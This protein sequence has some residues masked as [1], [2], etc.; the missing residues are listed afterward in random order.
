MAVVNV[1][2]STQANPQKAIKKTQFS[3]GDARFIQQI[4]RSDVYSNKPRIII[5]EYLSNA[6]D[7]HRESQKSLTPVEIKLPT[8][9][10]NELVIRDYG[11]GVSPE[12]FENVFVQYGTSTKRDSDRQTGG[13]GIGAKSAWAYT[14]EYF[15]TSWTQEGGTMMERRYRCYVADDGW[16]YGAL[17]HED[18][19]NE[20]QQ[21]TEIS[22]TIKPEDHEKFLESF[23]NVTYFWGVRPKVVGSYVSY[24]SWEESASGE[25]WTLFQRYNGIRNG[26]V[27]IIDGIPYAVM[28]EELGELSPNERELVSLPIHFHAETGEVNIALNRESLTY[29]EKTVRYLKEKINEVITDMVNQV[30]AALKPCA[31]FWLAQTKWYKEFDNTVIG[32]IIKHAKWNGIEVGHGKLKQTDSSICKMHK[33]TISHREQLKPTITMRKYDS[34]E[35]KSDVRIVVND[36]DKSPSPNRLISV[37]QSIPEVSTFYVVTFD[38]ENTNGLEMRDFWMNELHLKHMGPIFTSNFER[39]K[40]PKGEKIPKIRNK[41]SIKKVSAQIMK[42]VF[43]HGN[44]FYSACGVDTEIDLSEIEGY[45]IETVRGTPYIKEETVPRNFAAVL[46][47]LFKNDDIYYVPKPL[48]G[49]VKKQSKLKLIDEEFDKRIQDYRKNTN[50]E[51]QMRLVNSSDY[52][53]FKNKHCGALIKSIGKSKRLPADHIFQIWYDT[54]NY[55][56]KNLENSRTLINEYTDISSELPTIEGFKGLPILENIWS[57]ITSK[58]PLLNLLESGYGFDP[59]L[60]DRDAFIEYIELKDGET[61]K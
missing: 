36:T 15:V 22:L 1:K 48:W 35:Y 45:Y 29:D 37:F 51:P 2:D 9:A 61:Y 4:L 7:A 11:P 31:N 32:K 58:Y 40:P 60:Q 42:S 16:C 6:R 50:I 24:R 47:H 38:R 14:D 53:S 23:H 55:I 10:N 18:I 13:F 21:G 59:S 57:D 33:V 49:K 26:P 34:W 41:L 27:A 8:P 52:D 28:P 39:W 43:I 46:Y 25:N 3:I 20:A 19:N 56:S 12:R 5:Q 17:E 44:C 30:E 54:S